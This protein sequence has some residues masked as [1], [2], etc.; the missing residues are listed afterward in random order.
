[1]LDRHGHAHH[2]LHGFNAIG[3]QLRGFHQAGTKGTA[4]HP[5]AGAAAVQIDFVIAPLRP[6]TRGLRQFF[7]LIAA[8]LQ[9]DGV[10]FGVVTQVALGATVQNAARVHHL[11]VEQRVAG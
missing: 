11:G 10:F 1:M 2:I 7:R 5:I 3:H 8:Q 9:G 6:Q 4:L